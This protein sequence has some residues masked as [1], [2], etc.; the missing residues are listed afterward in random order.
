MLGYLEMA[1]LLYLLL[2][3]FVRVVGLFLILSII[4]ATIIVFVIV[5]KIINSL[6]NYHCQNFLG[7]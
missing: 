7:F 5:I 1:V 4:M 6:F 3:L 2:V